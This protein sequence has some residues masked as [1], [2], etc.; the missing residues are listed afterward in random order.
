MK[1]FFLKNKFL[2]LTILLFGAAS[3]AMTRSDFYRKIGQSQRLINEIYKQVFSSYVDELDPEAFTKASIR[4]ITEELDPYTVFMVEEER[5]NV[6]ILAKGKYGGVGI[7]LGWRNKKLSVIAPMDGGPA[8]DAGIL[9]GDIILKVDNAIVSEISLDEAAKLIRGKKGTSVNLSILRYGLEDT[10]SFKLVRREIKVKDVTYSGMLNPSTGY[11]RLSRFSKNSPI[12]MRNAFND[13]LEN[14]AEE[15]I[16]DLRDNPGGLLN[17]AISILDMVIPQGELLVTTKGRLEQSNK[18]YHSRKEPLVPLRVKLAVLINQGSASASEIVSGAIQ[19]LDRGIVLGRKSFGKGLVQSVFGL[20]E[21]RSLK[22]TTAKYYIPSGRLI[23][24]QDYINENYI[25]QKMAEDSIFTTI[26]GRIVQGGGGITPDSILSVDPFPLLT[27]EYWR[28]GYFFSYAQKHK[29]QYAGLNNVKDDDTL[30]MNFR[31][32]TEQNDVDLT[33]PGEKDLNHLEEKLVKLDSTDS[34]LKNS[35]NTISQFYEIKK[36]QLFTEEK[37]KI[38]ELL[39]IE[40]A[41]LFGGLEGRMKESL[42]YDNTINTVISLLKDQ[43]T[44]KSALA[45]PVNY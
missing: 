45:S 5:D 27:T 3:L 13:L 39:Y 24:K 26:G 30:L 12:E 1:R 37:E 20:D 6:N 9:S 23:Q 11:V 25:T 10:L 33:L 2:I 44:Y 31:K 15:I 4:K 21:K 41:G 17:A 38:R 7:Q 34:Q 29:H 18:S 32:F 22:I 8:K 16:I 14:D 40:F 42:N 36:T 43:T 28:R 19:D 35:I